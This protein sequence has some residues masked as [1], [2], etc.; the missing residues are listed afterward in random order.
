MFALIMWDLILSIFYISTFLYRKKDVDKIKCNKNKLWIFFG[1]AM[2]I[3][4][5]VIKTVTVRNIESVKKRIREIKSKDKVEWD[6]YIYVVEKIAIPFF[7]VCI[8]SLFGTVIKAKY[9]GERKEIT[10][11]FREE[12]M[13]KEMDIKAYVDGKEENFSVDIFPRQYTREEA[14]EMLERCGKKLEKIM[15]GDNESCEH[16]DSN[17]YLCDAMEERKVNISWDISDGKAVDDKGIIS[18]NVSDKGEDVEICA[19]L[20]YRQY[21]KE[22]RFHVKVF[23]KNDNENLGYYVQKA[24]DSVDACKET[25]KLPKTYRGKKIKY[26]KKADDVGGVFPILGILAAIAV[27]VIKDKD[28]NKDVGLRDAQM[29]ADY[30]EIISSTMLL[31][32]AGMSFTNAWE[33]ILK[34]NHD[35]KNRYAY[36]EMNNTLQKIRSGVSEYAAL[37]QFGR[38]CAIHSYVRF[39]NIINQNLR[40]GSEDVC[41]SL[42]E[43][44][45]RALGERK[46]SVLREGEEAGTK[47]LAPMIIMLILCIVIIV[48]PAF[49]S[50]N[51]NL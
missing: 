1:T 38:N 24:I 44:L 32:R 3:A 15:L 9:I 18:E 4:D 43:E 25:I 6:A 21:S 40:R 23:P 36:R 19:T 5:H 30:P 13:E 14:Y 7:I 34:I 50:V 42:E 11:V 51:T 20:N 37:E 41:K 10:E 45:L 46:S 35:K 29:L 2:F 31:L 12:L 39:S 26:F 8:A 28:L 27:F 48:V 47:L 16:V 49:L 22:I 17:L 33:V